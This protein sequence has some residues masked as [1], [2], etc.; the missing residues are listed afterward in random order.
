[1][2][3]VHNFSAGPAALPTE[4]L[5]IAQAEMLDYR[6]K[7]LSV[8]EMSHRSSEF[9]EIAATAERDLR[10]LL[11]LGDE[12]AV[13]FMQGGATAQFAAVPLN[14]LGDKASADYVSTGAWS[15]KAV[16][17]A[18][19]YGRVNVVASSEA[20]NFDRIPAR[21]DWKLD[22]GAAYVHICGNETIGGVEFFD[23]PDVGT[24]PLVADLSSNL[25]SRPMDMQR[26]ALVYAG[27]Q[28]NIGPAGIAVVIVRRELFGRA[29]KDTPSVLDYKLTADN[30]SMYNTPPTYAWY[31]AGLVFKW[32]KSIGGVT[33]MGEINRRKA[34]TLYRAIDASNFYRCPVAKEARSLM[35]VPF[36]LADD[37][38]DDAF[39]AGAEARGLTNL[40]GHRSVGGMRAS[41]YNAVP[42]AAVDALVSYMG[43]FEKENA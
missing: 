39:L 6:G 26:F 8:M 23:I 22:P 30:D 18:K 34:A 31:L 14:L 41:L 17:E 33:A 20:S 12:F 27:A 25:L 1:M 29:R 37:A 11:A 32:L 28:K 16:V 9:I 13:L 40:K 2:T 5:E 10:E 36:T 24:V 7:G 15:K 35:N 3:R 43:E 21:A 38:L 42:Q 4:V 19:R